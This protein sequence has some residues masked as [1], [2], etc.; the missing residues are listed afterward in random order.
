VE[1]APSSPTVD[2][3][4]GAACD[5]RLAAGG[6]VAS[7]TMGTRTS[8]ALIGMG[9]ALI[10]VV[11]LVLA[12][13]GLRET[14]HSLPE[15]AV[16]QRVDLGRFAVTVHRAYLTD[17]DEEGRPLSKDK[18]RRHIV[19]E[20]T[21][22]MLD[23][24]AGSFPAGRKTGSALLIQDGRS[25]WTSLEPD[26]GGGP[27]DPLQPG[28]PT[29]ARFYFMPP[30]AVPATVR[31]VLG[32]QAYGWTNLINPGPEWSSVA[33]PAVAVPD[34]PLDDRTRP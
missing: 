23:E 2:C 22:E 14:T 24:E 17:K 15:A 4:K 31:V 10:L 11:G 28:I 18:P 30:A 6:W 8:R 16:D 5:A 13:G 21:V 7:T 25:P 34:V 1:V 9:A 20:A 33:V 12:F 3:V 32:D 27:D 29:Q 19:V 26:T